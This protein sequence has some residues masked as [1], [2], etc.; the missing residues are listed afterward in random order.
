[1]MVSRGCCFKIMAIF[2]SNFIT[3]VL[4]INKK[5]IKKMIKAGIHH[6]EFC[7]SDITQ[8]MKFYGSFLNLI[9]WEKI[10]ANSFSSGETTIYFVERKNDEKA[11]SLGIRDLC[12]QATEKVQVDQIYDILSAENAK[13]IRGPVEMP[14]SEGYYTVD[15]Y[16]PD[17]QILEVA[18]TPN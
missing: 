6:L 18:Y 11:N 14:Y 16:D 7:V 13:I 2:S 17:G 4:E 8:S 9:G 3:I 12:F 5:N 1:M 15:F 10:S